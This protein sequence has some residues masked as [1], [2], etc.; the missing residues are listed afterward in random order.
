[1]LELAEQHH[2]VQQEAFEEAFVWHDERDVMSWSIYRVPASAN[3]ARS[4][5]EIAAEDLRIAASIINADE[6][7][8]EVAGLLGVKRLTG[9]ARERVERI[10]NA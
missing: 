8:L 6:R 5:E 3:D 1:M 2:H 10:L 4:I 7:A 9:A